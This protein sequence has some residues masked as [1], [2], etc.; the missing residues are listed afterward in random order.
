MSH[1][2]VSVIVTAG[3]TPD[4]LHAGLQS[5]RPNLGL[6]DEVVCVLP[7]D[8]PELRR[9]LTGYR[10]LT[11]L[12][13]QPADQSGRWAAG[14]AA[15][16][17]PVVVLL[18]GDVIGGAQWLD[19]VLDAFADPDVVAAGPRC[20]RTYGPQHADL[21]K[22]A[23]ASAGRF[24]TFARDWHRQHRDVTTVDRLGP[25]CLAV[26]RGALDRAGGPTLDMPYAALADQGR[27]VV[28]DGA[29]VAH[30]GTDRCGL[31]GEAAVPRPLLSA[32][33]IVKDEEEV[34]GACLDALHPFVDEIVVYDTGST[35]ASRRIARE[36]GARVVE[37]YWNEHFAD[38]RNR[39]LAHCQG[40]WIFVVDADEIVSG[41]PAALREQLSGTTAAALAVLLQS[42][43]GHGRTGRA[44]LAP[45][46][47]RRGA[48][49]TG[50]LHEQGVD[51][52]TGEKLTSPEAEAVTLAHS[53]YD[54]L[55]FNTKDK[56]ARNLRLAE[57]HV[58]EEGGFTAR[59]NLARSQILA[60][61]A[62]ESMQLCRAAIAEGGGDLRQ[63]FL[64]VLAHA[65]TA[66]GQREAA[67]AALTD[68]RREPGAAAMAD[69]LE[70]RLR[71]MEGDHAAAMA[72]LERLPERVMDGNRMVVSR[73]QLADAEIVARY[74]LG[75]HAGAADLLSTR[76]VAGDLPV[77]VAHM[78]QV[79]R[80][81]GRDVAT[82]A[83]LVPRQSLRALLF[84][85]T[86]APMS[87]ADEVLE[88]LWHRYPG[89]AAV[90]ALAARVG[91]HLPLLRCLEW[92]ARLRGHGFADSCTLVALAGS[93]FRAARER[94]LAAAM[95]VEMY[96]DSRAM[97]LL[98]QALAQV[99]DEVAGAVFAEMRLLAPGVAASVVPAGV[100]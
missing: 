86:E 9:V 31:R 24:K 85:L 69:D 75:D 46:L 55:R 13:D 74:E 62:A 81:G 44:F 1:A 88:A 21:P 8:R 77:P 80:A 22:G 61:Q 47:F 39:S 96:G 6:R 28:V 65:A 48:R 33:M 43:E 84:A 78:V 45:R 40:E 94:A 92:A 35:D 70:V 15:T 58:A 11:V 66:A 67:W 27:L 97:P 89:D 7:P 91:P 49:Y 50:R 3:G 68:L 5:L 79:L 19:R 54:Q 17:H 90:L 100:A 18:D 37:G 76:L 98:T 73:R 26:R 72:I 2:P 53:G 56:A 25:V 34:L 64:Q 14:V 93:G 63:S 51:G 12:A 10:W 52:I 42:T 36:H 30:V 59:L 38:A 32:S 4:D 60:G 57:L 82:L 41:D 71:V 20:H 95:A 16:T 83:T 29:L 99:S 23:M 87:L